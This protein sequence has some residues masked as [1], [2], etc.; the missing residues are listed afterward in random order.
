MEMDKPLCNGGPQTSVHDT[1][2]GLII[3]ELHADLMAKRWSVNAKTLLA[4]TEEVQPL[5]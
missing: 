1:I 5:R 2:Q 4:F 3:A